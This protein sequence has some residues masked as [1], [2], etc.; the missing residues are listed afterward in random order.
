MFSCQYCEIFKNSFFIEQRQFQ[1]VYLCTTTITSNIWLILLGIYFFYKK[2]LYNRISNKTFPTTWG[3]YEPML[4]LISF[5]IYY[6]FQ[7]V[8]KNLILFYLPI[9]VSL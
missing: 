7:K 1:A 9:Y 6:T 5:L 4:Y 8:N 2:T 3:L